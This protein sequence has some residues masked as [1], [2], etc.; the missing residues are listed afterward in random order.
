MS[1]M[2]VCV[3]VRMYLMYVCVHVRMYVCMLECNVKLVVTGLTRQWFTMCSIL[4]VY[5]NTRRTANNYARVK[6]PGRNGRHD[7][8]GGDG[9]NLAFGSRLLGVI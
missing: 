5:P 7:R 8:A 6:I 9:L 1:V 4:Y 3:H 2:H